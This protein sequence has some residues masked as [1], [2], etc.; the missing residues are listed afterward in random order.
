MFKATSGNEALRLA[1]DHDLAVVLLDVEMPE[2]DG[3]ETAQRGPIVFVT[4]GDRSEERTFRSYA[5]GPVEFLYK[6]INTRPR[7]RLF[8]RLD[9][10][11]PG[12]GV[13]LTLCKRAVEKLRDRPHARHDLSLHRAA[14][15][16]SASQGRIDLQLGEN[17]D[18][19][20]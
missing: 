16:S 14:Q 18:R 19:Q 11:A 2:M 8:T 12:T 17:P 9:S 13:G 4:A 10:S 5:A 15:L 7:V 6:P 3:Y 20:E 1:L